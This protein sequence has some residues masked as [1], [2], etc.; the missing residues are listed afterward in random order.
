MPSLFCS[1]WKSSILSGFALVRRPIP[2][3][4]TALG[5]LVFCHT[6]SLF[7]DRIAIISSPSPSS[8]SSLSPPTS[9]G[10]WCQSGGLLL[11]F[12]LI[13]LPAPPFR[14]SQKMHTPDISNNIY[15]ML[16]PSPFPPSLSLS[17]S[18]ALARLLTLPP[19]VDT[20]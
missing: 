17:F 13:S 14:P 10:K 9:Q 16:I 18:L 7:S 11:A 8:A 6:R 1:I 20:I 3:A 15:S 19:T 2:I 5:T 4:A 12:D